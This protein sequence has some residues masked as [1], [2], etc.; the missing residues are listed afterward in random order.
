MDLKYIIAS[1]G[2]SGT[3]AMAKIFTQ[4]GISCGHESIFNVGGLEEANKRLNNPKLIENS[5][6]SEFHGLKN[7]EII[8]ESSFMS[9]PFLSEFKNSTIIHLVRNPM[10][11]VKSWVT[12][13]NA[14]DNIKT[15]NKYQQFIYKHL[16]E[17]KNDMSQ[18]D[19]GCLYYILWN[20][21]IQTNIF[22]RIEDPIETLSTQLNIGLKS[23]ESKTINTKKHL[24][25]GK[26]NFNNIEQIQDSY[27]KKEFVDIANKYG[28][29]I[30]SIKF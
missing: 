6:V 7:Q 16:P 14:F 17:L 5:T 28:Y 24:H 22:Y 11:V 8:A 13:I 15:D 27:I 30:G 29:N 12:D 3:V 19:R 9:V 25:L 21:L 4:S 10:H 18:I 20:K 2:H 26:V 23:I 1:T